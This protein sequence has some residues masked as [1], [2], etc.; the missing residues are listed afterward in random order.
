M[1]SAKRRSAKRR[2]A[3]RRSARRR[4]VARFGR[5][6]GRVRGL[7][8]RALSA[9]SVQMSFR[10][11]GTDRG[12]G[13]AVQTYLVKQSLKPIRGKRGVARAQSLC[14]GTCRFTVTK[15]NTTLTLT[16]TDLRPNTTYHYTIAARDNLTG[17]PGPPSPSNH[18]RTRKG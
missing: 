10:A 17:R 3:K 18:A 8:V 13:E 6:P 4:C 15:V 12:R 7:R 14:D 5:I 1:R 11:A 2:S 16:I 9:T